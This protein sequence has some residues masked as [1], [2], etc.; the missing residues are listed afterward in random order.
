L[1]YPFHSRI[2][3]ARAKA[4]DL[5]CF[6]FIQDLP[7]CRLAA[8]QRKLQA[9]KQAST[10]AKTRD[11]ESTDEW[12][13]FCSLVGLVPIAAGLKSGD[14]PKPYTA[15]FVRPRI[16]VCGPCRFTL[17][18]VGSQ[19]RGIHADAAGQLAPQSSARI[20]RPVPTA[21]FA[22]SVAI[23]NSQQS[24]APTAR[25]GDQPDPLFLPPQA[26]HR[27]ARWRRS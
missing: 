19:S 27:A 14:G 15:S 24:T 9:G 12:T 7:F 2:S 23:A 17:P 21:S 11:G 18:K 22:A 25:I 4:K 26:Q 6:F 13:Q 16:S 3:K 8:I 1:S 10:P 5:P 20:T